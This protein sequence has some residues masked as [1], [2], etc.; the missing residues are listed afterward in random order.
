M[1]LDILLPDVDALKALPDAGFASVACAALA[2]YG[3]RA[4]GFNLAA[5]ASA[6]LPPEGKMFFYPAEAQGLISASFKALREFARDGGISPATR[7]EFILSDVRDRLRTLDA[8]QSSP[9]YK[10]ACDKALDQVF[11]RM[12]GISSLALAPANTLRN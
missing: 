3:L 6:V 4:P 8:D 9:E 5:G 2:R 11:S 10:A 7:E 1:T 12:T